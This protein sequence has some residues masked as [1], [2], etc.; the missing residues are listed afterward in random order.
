ME[1]IEG[2]ERIELSV[3]NY[4]ELFAITGFEC[5][6]DESLIDAWIRLFYT[7]L[8]IGSGQERFECFLEFM[9]VVKF[10][11]ENQ[12]EVEKMWDFIYLD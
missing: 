11:K 2:I 6:R 7:H 8:K 5:R 10:D 9:K 1:R 3:T 4:F 12:T